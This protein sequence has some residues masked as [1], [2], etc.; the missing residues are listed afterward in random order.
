MFPNQ[1][2]FTTESIQNKTHEVGK[3]QALRKEND[4]LRKELG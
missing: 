1:S 2:E 3:V 4:K